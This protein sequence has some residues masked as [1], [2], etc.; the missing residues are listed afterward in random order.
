MDRNEI[1]TAISA[2]RNYQDSLWGTTFDDQNSPNDWASYILRYTSRGCDFN[3]TSQD[4]KS[5][6]IK[7]AALAVAAIESVERKGELVKRHYD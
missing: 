6:M 1:F 7:V 5:A 2:E 3:L 4:F